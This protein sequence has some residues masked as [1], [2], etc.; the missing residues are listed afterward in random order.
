M[1]P[2]RFH[3]SHPYSSDPKMGWR[4]DQSTRTSLVVSHHPD[5]RVQMMALSSVWGG[6]F[7]FCD[8]PCFPAARAVPGPSVGVG[9]GQRGSVPRPGSRAL[10]CGKMGGSGLQRVLAP[11]TGMDHRVR[12][13]EP[14]FCPSPR[15]ARLHTAPH[16]P[17]CWPPPSRTRENLSPMGV[18]PGPT[19]SGYRAS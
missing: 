2:S 17:S 3:G 6:W 13:F 18:W 19:T 10:W 8:P 15:A 4:P 11:N 16:R 12:L 9:G 5:V 14:V 7:S 1:Y